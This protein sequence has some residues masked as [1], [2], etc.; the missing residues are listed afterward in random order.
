MPPG[1]PGLLRCSNS[2]FNLRNLGCSHGQLVEAADDH[3][4]SAKNSPR[5]DGDAVLGV[6]R[7]T[8]RFKPELASVAP[9]QV[10]LLQLDL[11]KPSGVPRSPWATQK[12]WTLG[13]KPLQQRRS[14]S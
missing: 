1:P 3:F 12:A 6:E 13:L 7:V 9:R 10:P 5:E 8:L 11:M 2:F 4:H 14:N